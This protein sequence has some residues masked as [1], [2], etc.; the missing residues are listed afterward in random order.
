[1]SRIICLAGFGDNA[2]LFASL[3]ECSS[4]HEFIALNLPGFGAP[5]LQG[6]TDFENLAAYLIQQ[7]YEYK[8][9][10]VLAH[11]VASITATVAAQQFGSPITTILSLEGNLTAADAYFSGTAAQYETADDFRKAFLDRLADMAEDSEI[12]ARYRNEVSKADPRPLWE[13]GTAAYHYSQAFIPG[14]EW[15]EAGKA[16][17]IYDDPNVPGDS[18][19]WLAAN[20]IVKIRLPGASHWPT[21]D[22]PRAVIEAV[23]QALRIFN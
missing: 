11:S 21:I 5:P 19:N 3:S 6:T 13:L 2:S 14:D 9:S 10:I 4:D 23:S 1:M 22:Q 15:K 20:D 12:V 16:A 18:L 17:Y 7:M 8:A